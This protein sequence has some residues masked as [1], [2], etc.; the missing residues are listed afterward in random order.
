MD[1][2]KF[3][4]PSWTI[5]ADS[6]KPAKPIDAEYKLIN[7]TKEIN[8]EY[9]LIKSESLEYL[10]SDNRSVDTSDRATEVTVRMFWYE[11]LQESKLDLLRSL[12]DTPVLGGI[13]PNY[14]A[15]IKDINEKIQMAV[16]KFSDNLTESEKKLKE[17]RMLSSFTEISRYMPH[18]SRSDASF[19][20][21]DQ[22][23]GVGVT[24]KKDGT[25][26]LLVDSESQV[27]FS[28]ASKARFGGLFRITGTAK[29]TKDFRNSEKIQLL[30]N[31]L[32]SK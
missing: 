22:S 23:D 10:Y 25:L 19:F 7:P 24:I 31:L 4:P 11:Q 32:E 29:M 15:T 8:T 12:V 1:L 20:V 28:Y 14:Y 13:A 6:K 17:E 18:L 9:T 27:K 5:K 26:S 30:L 21:D 3:T 2:F 16:C